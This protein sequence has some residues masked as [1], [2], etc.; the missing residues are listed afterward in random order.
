MVNVPDIHE[1]MEYRCLYSVSREAGDEWM[2]QIM[3]DDKDHAFI[4]VPMAFLAARRWQERVASKYHIAGVIELGDFILRS[5]VR[6]ALV[7]LTKEVPEKV[8]FAV[9]DGTV[10]GKHVRTDEPSLADSYSQEYGTYLDT[11]E[12]WFSEEL[13]STDNRTEKMP[14]AGKAGDERSGGRKKTKKK[15]DDPPLSKVIPEDIPGICS[16]NVMDADKTVPGILNP[17]YYTRESQRLLK[18]LSQNTVKLSDVAQVLTPEMGETGDRA[19]ILGPAV[20]KYPFVLDDLREDEATTVPLQDGDILVQRA[21]NMPQDSSVLKT[22]FYRE[23]GVHDA[24]GKGTEDAPVCA[25][26]N[27]LVIRCHSILPEYLYLYLTSPSAQKIV[28]L[29]TGGALLRILTER[30]VGSIPVVKPKQDEDVYIQDVSRIIEPGK[31]EYG[32]SA[33]E[34]AAEYEKHVARIAKGETRAESLED[35]ICADTARRVWAIRNKQLV[36]FLEGDIRE[37]N[38]CY[39]HGAYKATL[40]LAGSILE[41][42]LIDWLSEIDHCDYFRNQMM[43]TGNDGRR[44]PATLQDYIDEI[45][46]INR[47]NW[48]GEA[49]KAHKIRKQRNLVHAKLCMKSDIRIDKTACL[50]VISYLDDVLRTRV[51]K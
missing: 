12:E 13:F 32:E 24:A 27:T 19:R 7:H 22:Y 45:K 6:F 37:L 33:G 25:G 36:Q 17:A 5:Q 3:K 47:P 26:R 41:A 1:L 29:A 18:G 35:A 9:Y 44:R 50:Q 38:I 43:M 20:F 2:H 31:R 40:I 23:Q 49:G 21:S 11:V 8:R 4:I 10:I 34:K 15:S 14:E 51:K 28:A 30:S 46:Y 48:M 16:F 39:K 42:V